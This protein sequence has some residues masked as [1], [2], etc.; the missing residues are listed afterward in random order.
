MRVQN[1][2]LRELVAEEAATW[3]VENREGTLTAQQE[4]EF[5]QWLQTSPV[6][7]AEYLAISGLGRDIGGVAKGVDTPVSD[8]IHRVAAESNI[9]PLRSGNDTRLRKVAMK[10]Q[11]RWLLLSSPVVRF[12]A[13]TAALAIVLGSW[14]WLTHQKNDQQFA[15]RHREQR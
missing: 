4:E 2:R 13:M 12:S 15:T 1:E 5:I 10:R 9:K 11:R 7:V 14:S 6:H 3:F 8:L